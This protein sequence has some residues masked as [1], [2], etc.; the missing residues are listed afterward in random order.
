MI[1]RISLIVLILHGIHQNLIGQYTSDT[2][3]KDF[4]ND[5]IVDTLIDFREMGSA[6]AGRT[7]S[8]IDGKTNEKFTLNNDG[9]YSSFTNVI[10]VPKNLNLKKNSLFLAAI[11]DKSLPN[12]RDHIDSSLKWLLS[13]NSNVR[14]LE[15]H[16]YFDIIANPKTAWQPNILE[17]PDSY[18]I[19]SF[20]Y[21]LQ[22]EDFKNKN[23]T[24]TEKNQEYVAYYTYGHQIKKIDSLTPVA[25]NDTYKIFKT[26]HTVFVKKGDTYN[27]AFISDD[28]VTGAPDRRSWPSINQVQLIDKYLIIHHDVPPVNG[29]FIEIINIETQKIGHL[30]FDPSHNNW[31]DEGGMRTFKITN[32]LLLFT[33]YAEEEVM[34]IPLKQLFESLD[35]S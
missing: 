13:G 6:C 7:V 35:K 20:E 8:I 21:S 31:T 19:D 30:K 23:P 1:K 9:C 34:K 26:A 32:D 28:L 33:E 27:W 16:P 2:I 18:Y 14:I 22:S 12:K 3:I 5:K 24:V 25:Q 29:Y 15:S 10:K 17:I 4:N 11:K